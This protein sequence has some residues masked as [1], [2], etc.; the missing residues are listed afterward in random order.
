M[1]EHEN[2]P[3]PQ[4]NLTQQGA[5]L[6]RPASNRRIESFENLMIGLLESSIENQKILQIQ[7]LIIQNLVKKSNT[8]NNSQNGEKD[9]H[10]QP[11]Q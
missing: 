11:N 10:P 7:Q 4:D 1:A 8:E 5:T 6:F 2:G 9:P 3:H